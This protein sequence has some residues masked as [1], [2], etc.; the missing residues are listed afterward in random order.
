MKNLI[1]ATQAKQRQVAE[2]QFQPLST[3]YVVLVEKS[4]AEKMN[5]LKTA[6]TEKSVPLLIEVFSYTKKHQ[7]EKGGRS[8]EQGRGFERDFERRQ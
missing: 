6:Y 3:Y 5:R 7:L 2:A 1:T 4:D 8:K